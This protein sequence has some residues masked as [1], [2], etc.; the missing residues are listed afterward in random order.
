VKAI[1]FLTLFL[2]LTAYGALAQSPVTLTIANAPGCEIPADFTGVSFGATAEIPDH[3]G[4]SGCLFN[5]T[6]FQLITLFKNSGL[7]NLRL[8][9][10]TVEGTNASVPDHADIDNVFGFARAA[11]INVI[12]TLRLLNGDPDTA[13][14]DALYIWEHYRPLL[15]CFAI[16][17]EPDI[18]RYHYPPLGSGSDPAITNYES[19]LARWRIFAT[20][21]TNAVPGATFAG[22]DA[23]GATW[24]QLFARDEKNSGIVSL[25]TQHLYVGGRP[26]ITKDGPEK[27]P[28]TEAISNMLSAS[29]V[30]KK[31]PPFYEKVL[32]PIVA[33]GLPWRMTEADDYLK[34]V[35]NAS[36]AFASALWALD[37]LHW[38]AAHGCAGVNF[39]N[40]EWLKTDTVFLAAPGIYRINP[41][42]YGVRA[43]G[44]GSL[45]RVEPVKISNDQKLNLTAYAVTD[46][47]NIFVTIINKEQ[48]A[49]GRS[50][51]TTIAPEGYSTGKVAT[52]FLAAANGNVGATNGITL[53]GAEIANDALWRGKWTELAP[54]INGHCD[55]SV[56]AGSAAVVRISTR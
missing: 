45:G 48:G 27:I 21:V 44:L 40:T 7:R 14:A 52:M 3:G 4:A 24:A 15:S 33:A 43:F 47:T 10:S 32:T 34:G 25:I 42:A 1:F 53:G 23:A 2:F 22:P 35:E 26:F 38:F 17:N 20:A 49:E 54:L 12:Y 41:K 51:V 30:K 31:Y 9:G 5:A 56:P 50:A 13:A 18:R 6:N 16:G 8:G 19:Y 39:H 36:D 37:F 28:A 11:G 46:T 55:V 29:W